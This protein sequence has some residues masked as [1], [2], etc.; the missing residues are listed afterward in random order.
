MIYDIQY[1]LYVTNLSVE[2]V[3][4]SSTGGNSAKRD[5]VTMHL[6][7]RSVIIIK[8][9]NN[10]VSAVERDN[11]QLY[12]SKV[13]ERVSK[14]NRRFGLSSADQSGGRCPWIG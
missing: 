11:A 3:L 1:K 6:P 12:W 2:R 13:G 14:S 9:W 8:R 10:N 5:T 7:V 4:G